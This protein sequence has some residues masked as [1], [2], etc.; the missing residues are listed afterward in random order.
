MKR[1]CLLMLFVLALAS[2]A[3]AQQGAWQNV[4]TRMTDQRWAPDVVLL[5]DGHTAL[6]AGGY[7]YATHQCVASAD[8]F[9]E[10]TGAFRP[11]RGTLNDDRD[12]A[13]ATL[14]PNGSVLIAGGFNTHTGSLDTAEIFD[15]NT[16]QFTPLAS[17]LSRGRELF[18]ATTLSDGRV[19]LS[20][21][22]DLWTGHTQNSADLFDP[23]TNTFTLTA[24]TL[25]QDR[26]GQATVRLADGRVLLVGGK[27]VVLGHSDICLAS[28]EIFD[29][30]TNRFH[31]A[32]APMHFPRDRPTATLLTDGTVLIAGGQDGKITP[33]LA[34]LFD[35]RT[36]KFT[37]LPAPLNAGR[38]AHGA[39]SLPD[40]RVL[41]AGGWNASAQA[42]IAST[43]IY[44]PQTRLFSAGA[45]L[46]LPV[47]DAGWVVFPDGMVLCAG[48]KSVIGGLASSLDTGAVWRTALPMKTP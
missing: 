32:K 40:G 23:R 19:L 7:S 2:R 39:V 41:L 37:L 26:F 38:M 44:D 5:E 10:R 14:L 13:T 20:G 33:T 36:E 22:L 48:G 30:R 35:S 6:I 16:E 42:S 12:F 31:R 15:P 9:D 3:G 29:P 45:S 17:R 25:H 43:E 8:L 47:L 21:G 34:E 46:P 28:A 11:C 4:N 24:N 27:S 18:G 1:L